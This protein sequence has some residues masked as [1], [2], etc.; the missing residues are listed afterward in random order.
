MAG[1][2][3]APRKLRDENSMLKRKDLRTV[4]VRDAVS[5]TSSAILQGITRHLAD[6]RKLYVSSLVPRNY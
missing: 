6:K 5:A 4:E 1:Q 2:I 3:I